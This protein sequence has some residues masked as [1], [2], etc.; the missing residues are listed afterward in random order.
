M[1]GGV[2]GGMEKER[3][4]KEEERE[5]KREKEISSPGSSTDPADGVSWGTHPGF[6]G[7][8]FYR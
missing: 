6:V 4:I 8:L 3:G 2:A 1:K 5:R 7:V